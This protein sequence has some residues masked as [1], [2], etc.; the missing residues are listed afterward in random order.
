MIKPQVLVVINNNLKIFSLI[1]KRQ[2][3]VYLSLYF[4][5]LCFEVFG[6][7]LVF[8]LVSE[9]TNS[10][11]VNQS[12]AEVHKAAFEVI[13]ISD[14][15]HSKLMVFLLINILV[16]LLKFGATYGQMFLGRNV[17]VRLAEAIFKSFI[18]D[19]YESIV[20]LNPGRIQSAIVPKVQDWIVGVLIP[21]L[22]AVGS[23]IV[24][25]GIA[26]FML[27]N[28]DP[29]LRWVLFFLICF[30]AFYSVFVRQMLVKLGKLV[31]DSQTG[32]L[33]SVNSVIRSYKELKIFGLVNDT[34]E[35]F[36]SIYANYQQSSMHFNLVAVSPRF[37]LEG[38]FYFSAGVVLLLGN[39][40]GLAL[41]TIVMSLFGAIRLLP[42]TQGI[43]A[44][45]VA[46]FS[47]AA[48]SSELVSQ[49]R[50][51]TCSTKELQKDLKDNFRLLTF[52]RSIDV[53]DVVF[54]YA[55]SD[56]PA[57]GVCNLSIKKG[58]WLGLV[59]HS[60]CGK[61]TLLDLLAGM[62]VPSQG[63]ILIDGVSLTND[64]CLQWWPKIALV[65]Q[66]GSIIQGTWYDT[67]R[68]GNANASMDFARKC[69]NLAGL[70]DSELDSLGHVSH[71]GKGL[72]GG[73][74]TRLMIAAALCSE[75]VV[76]LLDEAN[77][78]LP[79]KKFTEICKN[80]KESIPELTVISVFH[81]GSQAVFMDEIFELENGQIGNLA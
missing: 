7:A 68:V 17:A 42:H 9:L 59:G 40:D 23:L 46:L 20:T 77:A 38:L 61:S 53:R 65:G 71:R 11:P 50:D 18:D 13:G 37:L 27:F 45:I 36:R 78:N 33:N 6:I 29:L 47:S 3:F 75:P 55:N 32:L 57:L 80:I 81:H 60:G 52:D 64:N 28:K 73:Q 14:D 1:E 67:V 8:P 5:T 4:V 25:V 19:S 63:E 66:S 35:E 79:D 12:L 48:I 39:S 34:K 15:L 10:Q 69:A 62:L 74:T 2:I 54:G 49:M 76:L 44:G 16:L 22:Q 30:Y 21:I 26:G 31:V 56:K 70:N 72:S 43:F 51:K 58:Q 24:T 41:E